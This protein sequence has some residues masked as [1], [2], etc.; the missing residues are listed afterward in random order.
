MAYYETQ[1]RDLM[2]G[3]FNRPNYEVEYSSSQREVWNDPG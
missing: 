1:I 3:Q 2:G